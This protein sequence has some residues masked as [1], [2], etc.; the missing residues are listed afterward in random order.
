MRRDA[1]KRLASRR[2]K[3]ME[4]GIVALAVTILIAV[5][6]FAAMA[7]SDASI[8]INDADNRIKYHKFA[9]GDPWNITLWNASTGALAY[10]FSGTV[11][12]MAGNNAFILFEEVSPGGLKHGIQKCIVPGTYKVYANGTHEGRLIEKTGSISVS[13]QEA[14]EPPIPPIPELSTVLLTLVGLAGMLML[15]RMQKR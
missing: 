14:C 13:Q 7:G 11:D 10:Q 12:G 15:L 8:V 5:N 6:T 2:Q 9:L 1:A 4:K 3:N